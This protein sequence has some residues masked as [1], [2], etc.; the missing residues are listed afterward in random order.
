MSRSDSDLP[1]F[2]WDKAEVSSYGVPL[3]KIAFPNGEVDFALLEA[4]NKD[5][6]VFNGYLKYESTSYVAMSGVNLKRL[7]FVAY[8]HA[9]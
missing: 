7:F 1:A 5:Y 8:S 6:C 9:N 3:L 2:S 4:V